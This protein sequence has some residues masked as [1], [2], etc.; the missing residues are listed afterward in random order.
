MPENQSDCV[1]LSLKLLQSYSASARAAFL[2]S[3]N[4]CNM[5]EEQLESLPTPRALPETTGL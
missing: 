2:E 3:L 4:V 1:I 5:S